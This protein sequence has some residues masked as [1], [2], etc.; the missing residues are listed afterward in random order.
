MHELDPPGPSVR[1]GSRADSTLPLMHKS[2]LA[3]CAQLHAPSASPV[4]TLIVSAS[5][6]TCAF[7]GHHRQHLEAV[8]QREANAAAHADAAFLIAASQSCEPMSAQ[9]DHSGKADGALIIAWGKCQV[10]A[11]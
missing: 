6:A 2:R 8:A 5:K 9:G 10:N 1:G 4:D 3:A 11:A 7:S